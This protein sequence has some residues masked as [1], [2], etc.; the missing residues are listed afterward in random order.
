LLSNEPANED[1]TLTAMELN[2]ISILFKAKKP[3]ASNIPAFS[4]SAKAS[5]STIY[6]QLINRLTI[7]DVDILSL[8]GLSF[9]VLIKE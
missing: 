3:F 5:V 7:N 9:S 1:P 4:T 6:D 8:E 2:P